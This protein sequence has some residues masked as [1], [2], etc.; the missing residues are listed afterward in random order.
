MLSKDLF[1]RL[2]YKPGL[3]WER[4][5]TLLTDCFQH[6]VSYIIAARATIHAFLLFLSPVRCT[7]LFPSHRLL[8]Y[9]IIVKMIVCS[10]IGLNTVPLTNHQSMEPRPDGSVA[11][12]SDWWLGGCEFHP[13]L[14][15]TFSLVYFRLSPLL[16]HV[17][18]VV[19]KKSCV[20][21]GVRKPGNTC[22][23]TTAIIWP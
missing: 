2:S 22:V 6:F 14:R 19:G 9:I 16:K 20:S 10:G 12:M 1:C 11:S 17:R 18:K 7:T 21:I 23:S 15:Q 5:T 3:V 13:R 4:L 8:S